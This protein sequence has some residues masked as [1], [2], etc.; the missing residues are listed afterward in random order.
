MGVRPGAGVGMWAH[1]RDRIARAWLL[2]VLV[3]CAGPASAAVDVTIEGVGDELEA[4]IEAFLS[5]NEGDL[6]DASPRRVRRL[7]QRAPGEIRRALE[8]FGYYNVRVDSELKGGPDDWH[9]RYRINPGERVRLERVRIHIT[10]PAADDPAFRQAIAQA[11][12]NEGAPLAHADYN[13]TKQRLTELAAQRGYLDANWVRSQLRVFPERGAAEAVLELGSGPRY[14][15]GEV[16]FVDSELNDSFL[17][18]YLQF[19]SGDPYSGSELLELQYALNDSD[20]FSRV[21]VMPLRGEAEDQRIPIQVRLHPRPQHRHTFGIGYGT[22]TGARVSVGREDRWVNRRGH[23]FNTEFQIAEERNRLSARYSVPLDQPWRE[24][25]EVVAAVGEQDIGDGRTRQRQ[26]GIQRVTTHAGWQSTV[27]VE[28]ERSTDEIGGHA[29]TRELVMPRLGLVRSNFNDPV[30]ATRGYR[31]SADLNGGT[32]TFG[33]DVS[34]LRLHLDGYYVRGLWPDGRVLLRGELGRTQIDDVDDLP[35]TQRF[36]AGGDQSVRGFAYQSLAPRNEDGDVIGGRYLGVASAELEQLVAGNWGAA[37][38]V[39]HGNAMNEVDS[40]RRTAAG[41]GLRY[42]SPVGV[43]R[44]DVAY[45]VDGMGGDARLHL[46]LG[47]DL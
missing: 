9:A 17:R 8:P 16:R 3:T 47:V 21:E 15:F 28:Y 29:V 26:I 44:V 24:R 23:R 40:D 6:A 43:F 7:H 2:G 35:L 19:E 20:Y 36:F 37:I 5:I 11:P 30:F 31:L 39:D 10:G 42:R 22:D 12:L 18:R 14:R 38:F 1:A 46:S 25:M 27:G 45:P 33:S 34:F 4:N 32:Q 41:I 13:A